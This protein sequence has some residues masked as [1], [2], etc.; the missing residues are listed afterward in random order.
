M[1]GGSPGISLGSYTFTSKE[2]TYYQNLTIEFYNQLPI[3]RGQWAAKIG[4]VYW[5]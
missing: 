5:I 1:G 2:S 4:S 3:G